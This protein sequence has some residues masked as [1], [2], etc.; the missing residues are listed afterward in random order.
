MK[1]NVSFL[2]FALVLV[3]ILVGCGASVPRPEIKDG[4]FE[5]SVS[6]EL[7]GETRTICG[8]YVCKY[9]GADWSLD[10]GPHRD[11][12]GYIKD[13]TTEE[14]ITLTVAENGG[15]VELNLCFSPN[16]FMG[17]SC[18]EDEEPFAPVITVRLE[19]EEGLT[20]E[21]DADRIAETYGAR[22]ISY[23]Y[24]EPIENVFN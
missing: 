8:V 24:A 11:W 5:F 18:C 16:H 1:K 17:D 23:D 15:I 12:G 20:F 10:G 4:E 21:N 7:N 19:N 3:G 22:I 14:R 2:L 13:G 6:Y 9:D